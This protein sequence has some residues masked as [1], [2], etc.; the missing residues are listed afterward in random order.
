MNPT[1]KEKLITE[2][3]CKNLEKPY[4]IYVNILWYFGLY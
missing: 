1:T 4:P 2:I 3:I